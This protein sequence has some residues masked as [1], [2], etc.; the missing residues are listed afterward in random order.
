MICLDTQPVLWGFRHRAVLDPIL[1]SL[2]KYIGGRMYNRCTYCAYCAYLKGHEDVLAELNA[3]L[4][5]KEDE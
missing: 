4:D 1:A 5:Q 3:F 2:P